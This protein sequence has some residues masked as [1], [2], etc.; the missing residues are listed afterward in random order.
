VRWPATFTG[1]ADTLDGLPLGTVPSIQELR[2]RVHVGQPWA[3]QMQDRI[4]VHAH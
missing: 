1:S 2:K 4:R 3:H